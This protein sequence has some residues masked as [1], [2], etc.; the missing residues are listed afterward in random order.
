MGPQPAQAEQ[1][2]PEDDP[3]ALVKEAQEFYTIGKAFE[4]DNDTRMLE[5]QNMVAGGDRQWDPAALRE[6]KADR[7]P[8]LTDNRLTGPIKQVT[9]EIR[10]NPFAI[11]VTPADGAANSETSQVLAGLIRYIERRSNAPRVYSR[12]GE[13]ICTGG[14]GWMRLGLVHSNEIPVGDLSDFQ[15]ELRIQS[16]RNAASVTID[17]DT[18]NDEDPGEKA[19]WAIVEQEMSKKDFDKQYPG[20]SSG[21]AASAPITS[22]TWNRGDK[23]IVAEFWKV[24]LEP[25]R[26]VHLQHVQPHWDASEGFMVPPSGESAVLLDPS[27]DELFEAESKGFII[28]QERQAFKKRVCFYLMGGTEILSSDETQPWTRIPLFRAV[29]EEIDIGDEVFRHGMIY[30]ARDNQ[31]RLNSAITL[32][33]E[34]MKQAPLAPIIVDSESV[35]TFEKE[36][37]AVGRRPVPYVRYNSKGG[38]IAAPKRMESIPANQGPMAQAGQAIDGIK[39]NTNV[40]DASMGNRSNETS[41]VAIEARAAQADTSTFVYQDNLA[42]TISAIGKEL[43]NVIPTI[44]SDRDMVTILG[45]DDESAIIDLREHVNQ[46]GPLS[47]GKYDINVK[48]GPAYE[49]KRKEMRAGLIDLAKSAPPPLQPLYHAKIAKLMDFDGA[50]EFADEIMQ[51]AMAMRLIPPPQG[52]MPPGMPPGMPMPPQGPPQGPPMGAPMNMRPRGPMP[53]AGPVPMRRPLPPPQQVSPRRAPTSPARVA[54]RIPAGRVGMG[55]GL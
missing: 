11:K 29:G 52:D 3:S 54:P 47:L 25:V 20:K 2:K 17:A 14:K 35:Q 15:T 31:R 16:I 23:V 13:H 6:R 18:V 53:Q 41:G 26:V 42:S 28:V 24:K 55:V 33:Y 1:T 32:D 9:G 51:A 19:K 8:I 4:R 10:R 34:M 44:M 40:F 5:D 12:C 45:E 30:H 37:A 7:R 49:S 21:F 39:A 46:F 38:T 36:W 48:T 27:E 22:R 50:A 43:V